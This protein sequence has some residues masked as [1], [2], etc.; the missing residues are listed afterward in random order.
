MAKIIC[1]DNFQKDTDGYENFKVWLYGIDGCCQITSSCWV[2][3]GNETA[4]Q[5]IERLS[6]Y[7]GQESRI[8]VANLEKGSCTWINPIE[9]SEVLQGILKD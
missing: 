3:T 8:F 2:V 1:C 5:I 4:K 7:L 6:G 9:S